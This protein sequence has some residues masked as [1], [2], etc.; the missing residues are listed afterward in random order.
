MS[1]TPSRI[2]GGG[3]GGRMPTYGSV[4]SEMSVL[5][6]PS[7]YGGGAAA[8]R[9]AGG[10]GNGG[11]V[12][13]LTDSE[14]N[15]GSDDTEDAPPRRTLR[16]RLRE[17]TLNYR[18]YAALLMEW[19]RPALLTL[20][21][22]LVIVLIAQ[23][24]PIW[25][26]HSNSDFSYVAN[27]TIIPTVIIMDNTTETSYY[28]GN[29]WESMTDYKDSTFGIGLGV[30]LFSGLGLILSVLILALGI[31]RHRDNRSYLPLKYDGALAL[32]K[33]G[34]FGCFVPVVVY[35][36]LTLGHV[37]HSSYHGTWG[38]LSAVFKVFLGARALYGSHFLLASVFALV[39][40]GFLINEAARKPSGDQEPH[41]PPP[42]TWSLGSRCAARWQRA[43]EL[44]AVSPRR[45]ER[46]R[47]KCV[48]R[49]TYLARPAGVAV[50][51]VVWIGL[52]CGMVKLNTLDVYIECAFKHLI[53]AKD[54]LALIK[55]R[56]R[57]EFSYARDMRP[58][59]LFRDLMRT[60]SNTFWPG[61]YTI[62]LVGIITVIAA[63]LVRTAL[64]AFLW[65]APMHHD[66]HAAVRQVRRI[67]RG[68]SMRTFSN[69]AV[70]L[71]HPR[72]PFHTQR[73]G[74]HP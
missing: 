3:D 69:A 72:P 32:A 9:A 43:A 52:Y 38:D 12:H 19:P 62:G 35:G 36:P 57:Y 5:K 26:L 20:A 25:E 2:D 31:A 42:G 65:L 17:A 54:G 58:I 40:F 64:I 66:S 73:L 27:I 41:P 13:H 18:V 49:I 51:A 34:L 67:I 11:D 59:T 10:Y 21:V 14:E 55:K 68:T 71:P 16:M 60:G 22:Q 45:I 24:L 70:P 53:E 48:S 61:N 15:G 44:R 74:V 7:S 4:R 1:E 63:P 29:V 6:P 23:T 50:C 8:S 56:L 46:L 39:T 28:N 30:F 37:E 47:W 33:W